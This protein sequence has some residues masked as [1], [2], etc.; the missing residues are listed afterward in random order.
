MLLKYIYWYVCL[1]SVLFTMA[2]QKQQVVETEFSTLHLYGW[3]P[4]PGV[5][6]AGLKEERLANYSEALRVTAIFPTL[7]MNRVYIHERE[8]PISFYTYPDTMPTSVPAK[9]LTLNLETKKIYSLFVGGTEGALETSLIEENFPLLNRADSLSGLRFLNLVKDAPVSINLSGEAYG[10]VARSIPFMGVSDFTFYSAK[11]GVPELF[12]EVRDAST[13]ELLL[14]I[15][16]HE[17]LDPENAQKYW[18]SRLR[19]YSL[20]GLRGEPGNSGNRMQV[21]DFVH[22]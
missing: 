15:N 16:T 20:I 2:C 5:V 3:I 19:T 12:F 18:M 8:Q 1:A 9:K 14:T 13:N 21:R 4:E 11:L 7:N 6:V 22:N 17:V 10:T